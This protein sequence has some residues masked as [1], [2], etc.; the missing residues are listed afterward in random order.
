MEP[1][2]FLS[3]SD[4]KAVSHPVRQRILA[5]MVRRGELS[6]REVVE[7]LPGAPANP[8]Y[9]LGVLREAGLIRVARREKRRGSQEKYYAPVART[10]SMDPGELVSGRG[11]RA[12]ELRRGI[13]SVARNGAEEALGGLARALERDLADPERDPPFVNLCT[14]RIRA[15]RAEELR[16]RL[17]AWV[18]DAVEAGRECAGAG[19]PG[20]CVDFTFYQLFFRAGLA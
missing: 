11:S 7:L 18:E 17:K 2:H 20:T 15:G 10:F 12:A 14:L 3:A 8:Y 9:H 13:L 1:I 4:L 16:L 19:E 5:L 6:G